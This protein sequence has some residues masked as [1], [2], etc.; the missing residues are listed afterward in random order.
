MDP[1]YKLKEQFLEGYNQSVWSPGSIDE[2]EFVDLPD[3]AGEEEEVKEG[4]QFKVINSKQIINQ[5][6]DIISTNKSWKQFIQ[7]KK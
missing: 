5:T 4:K 2:K 1:K 3:M 6:L 7:I